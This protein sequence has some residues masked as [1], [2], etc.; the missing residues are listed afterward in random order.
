M[1]VKVSDEYS[2]LSFHFISFRA[3][4]YK[5]HYF[6]LFECLTAK[7][8]VNVDFTHKLCASLMFPTLR[9]LGSIHAFHSHVFI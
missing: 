3:M 9:F 4:N 5:S 6:F 7:I 2:N 8:D 1:L